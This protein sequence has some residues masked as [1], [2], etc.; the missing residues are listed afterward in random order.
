MARTDIPSLV[1]HLIEK[2]VNLDLNKIIYYTYD[3]DSE[4]TLASNDKRHTCTLR[5]GSVFGTTTLPT[6]SVSGGVA[7]V[8][9]ECGPTVVFVLPEDEAASLI[10]K[11]TLIKTEATDLDTQTNRADGDPVPESIELDTS[12][13][14]NGEVAMN[15]AD[16]IAKKMEEANIITRE[17]AAP[18]K[19]P[20]TDKKAIRI[21]S[22]DYK[23]SMY[24]S[25]PGEK[26]R[27]TFD[28][29]KAP[30][31]TDRT[32]AKQKILSK[33]IR[34]TFPG[35]KASQNQFKYMAPPSK[36]TW[37]EWS[38]K[39]KDKLAAAIEK[40]NK[41]NGYTKREVDPNKPK[42]VR[43]S[44]IVREINNGYGLSALGITDKEAVQIL[45]KVLSRGKT[46]PTRKP[47]TK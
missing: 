20:A 40:Y 30:P 1:Q 38:T 18:G 24:R 21:L 6:G 5:K 45:V 35:V 22:S 13:S 26:Y 2:A 4:T 36:L 37:K 34:D 11:S 16:R 41:A 29:R 42:A 27:I 23:V 33:I 28:L 44:E 10:S 25:K 46:K 32:Y 9:E 3:G 14:I 8:T 31:T 47:L 39:C 15:I 12:I 7:I 17:V 19:K 43:A